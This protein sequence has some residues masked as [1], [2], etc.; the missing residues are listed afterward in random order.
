MTFMVVIKSLLLLI[1]II[2][3]IIVNIISVIVIVIIIV[4]SV[5]IITI[6][7]TSRPFCIR[8]P[9]TCS[10]RACLRPC[11]E[12][13]YDILDPRLHLHHQRLLIPEVYTV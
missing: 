5:I 1:I 8:F 2:I 11:H 13:R 6:E 3:I 4:I 7:L 12:A 9:L 10:L